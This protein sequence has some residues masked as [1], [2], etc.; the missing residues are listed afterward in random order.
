MDRP[1]KQKILRSH[2]IKRS[3]WI[4]LG[5]GGLTI[6]GWGMTQWASPSLSFQNY[7][8]ALV[9]YGEVESAITA[10]GRV[11]PQK[12]HLLVSPH[13][14]RVMQIKTQV[15]TMVQPGQILLQL[16]TEGIEAELKRLREEI[17]LKRNEKSQTKLTLGQILSELKHELEQNKLQQAFQK[18]T[19][20]RKN[21]LY[22]SGKMNPQDWQQTQ[23]EYQFLI[24]AE[25]RTK[26][27]IA[28]QKQLL[29]ERLQGFEIELSL[30]KHQWNQ[31]TRRLERASIRTEKAGLLTWIWTY[32]G[33]EV[34]QGEVLAR[35]ADVEAFRVD[36]R[37]S[38]TNAN[39]LAE[40]MAVKVKI[41]ETILPAEISQILPEINN[42][43]MTIQAR[44]VDS[45]HPL[46]K[47]NLRVDAL[48]IT[49]SRAQ[50]LRVRKGPF[51][52]GVGYQKV[53]V[54]QGNQAR[55]TQVHFGI[56]G[57]DY[58]KILDGLREGDKVI[59][60][61]MREYLKLAQI[62]INQ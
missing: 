34:E 16:N 14:L 58:Y 62:K 1:I 26:Q 48:L 56:A 23:L 20:K 2:W 9:E 33:A 25:E 28:F 10:S 50:T 52:N 41:G 59:I 8:I 60:S 5:I 27:A 24:L 22:Q 39:R 57:F 7:R 54:I 18:D 19:M 47:I 15:G 36:I 35:I 30:L 17:L 49:D 38:D 13:E 44:L 46:L 32:P 29:K 11:V 42:G 4:L 53:F 21:L 31:E 40:G 43:V 51:S 37:T 3:A 6:A 55:R 12:E 61:D 45:A